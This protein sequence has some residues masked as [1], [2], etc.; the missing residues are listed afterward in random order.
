MRAA[1]SAEQ[2][3]AHCRFAALVHGI[4]CRVQGF[5][6]GIQGVPLHSGRAP[7][8]LGAFG[9]WCIAKHLCREEGRGVV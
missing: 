1:P 4:G 6:C 3:E 5:G 2:R 7:I 8:P 9:A